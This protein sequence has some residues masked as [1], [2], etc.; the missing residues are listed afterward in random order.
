MQD[1]IDYILINNMD[2]RKDIKGCT[3][4][5]FMHFIF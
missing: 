3:P 2:Q 5:K 1:C 4:V